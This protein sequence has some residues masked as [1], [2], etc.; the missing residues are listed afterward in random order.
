MERYFQDEM[1][2]NRQK[3]QMLNS[4]EIILEEFIRYAYL[5]KLDLREFVKIE[6][7]E[8]KMKEHFGN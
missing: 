1:L 3:E 5:C 2:G 8:E 6:W 4:R 7:L